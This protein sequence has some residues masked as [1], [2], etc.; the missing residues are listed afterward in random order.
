MQTGGKIIAAVIAGAVFAS[1]ASGSV[2]L[3]VSPTFP[4]PMLVGTDDLHASV[5]ICNAS[6]GFEA[7]GNL[8]VTEIRLTPACGSSESPCPRFP[9]FRRE[10]GV[11]RINGTATG[12]SISFNDQACLGRTFTVELIDAG[13]GEVA[14]EVTDNLGS[15]EVGPSHSA[16][17]CCH[18][19]F[20]V[21]VIAEPKI[22]TDPSLP[23]T[24]TTQTA[25]ARAYSPVTD[26]ETTGYGIG[27]SVVLNTTPTPSPLPTATFTPTVTFTRSSTS[28][29]TRTR[30][31]TATST[32]SRTTTPTPAS[33]PVCPGD[34]DGNRD[35]SIAEVVRCS[36]IYLE[37]LAL[38]QCRVGDTN[39]DGAVSIGEVVRC[40]NS[41]Q[42]GCPEAPTVTPVGSST[43]TAVATVT[44]TGTRTPTRTSSST[45]TA[46]ATLSPPLTATAVVTSA[47]RRELVPC[48]GASDV[49]RFE[50]TAGQTLQVSANTFDVAGAADLCIELKCP[51]IQVFADDPASIQVSAP[52]SGTCTVAVA[53]CSP[54]CTDPE[55]ARYELQV[56]RNA[57]ITPLTLIGDGVPA[58]IS[59]PPKVTPTATPTIAADGGFSL[60]LFR[61]D[62]GQTYVLLGMERV[63]LNPGEQVGAFGAQ[64]TSMAISTAAI[65]ARNEP[66]PLSGDTVVSAFAVADHS[67]NI[68]LSAVFG[69]G[70]V[71]GLSS[72]EI[73]DDDGLRFNGEFLPSAN[74]GDGLLVLPGGVRSVAFRGSATEPVHNLRTSGGS[75]MPAAAVTQITRY[76]GEGQAIVFPNPAAVC[77]GGTAAGAG[78]SSDADCPGPN[79]REHR[80]SKPSRGSNCGAPSFIPCGPPLVTTACGPG[81]VCG[82]GGEEAG[83]NVT[84]DD[85]LN[86]R[87]GNPGTQGEQV[88]GFLLRP[89]RA[90]VAFIV[91][92]QPQFLG[93][94]AAGFLVTGT[95]M[96]GLNDTASCTSDAQCGGGTCS[97]QLSG[98][99]NR[100]TVSTSAV[101]EP[102]LR[103][104]PI[105]NRTVIA[106][107]ELRFEVT[108]S[109]PVERRLSFEA[110]SLPAGA[111][112][113][114][115][116]DGTRNG[117]VT[118]LDVPLIDLTG[119]ETIDGEDF[120][121]LVLDYQFD[122]PIN[123]FVFLWTPAPSQVGQHRVRFRAATP[124]DATGRV[125]FSLPLD[126]LIT[127]MPSSTAQEAVR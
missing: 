34:C 95:C 51:G 90:V 101:F 71:S 64:V 103:L 119:D 112:L 31:L 2:G 87:V 8:V 17:A 80:C 57:A 63:R 109:G 115:A 81:V 13:T 110:D 117:V 1:A 24:S 121:K 77:V 107:K 108:T 55:I 14:F 60:Q 7:H 49:W 88:D 91:D 70:V 97:T 9:S 116:G 20:Q 123:R 56:R 6:T 16:T 122:V 105:S 125:S 52:S 19:S 100:G 92:T 47:I 21:D 43:P 35:V 98:R 15:V 96:G 74:G 36:L 86:E 65:V 11:F 26:L 25:Q 89:L 42:F 12:E 4:N 50:A 38:S 69:T 30:T 61:S 83:Q 118:S 127:V 94:G 126:V 33:N 124:A 104:A 44:R 72:V 40:A 62:N 22:N 41:Y 32:P 58:V 79:D 53:V 113:V 66:I 18:I 93:A 67:T 82:L 10:P 78:C 39:A 59:P 99:L 84:I 76:N 85:T 23:V 54:A 106:G 3:G 68:P 111:Q 27:S 48:F 45:P 29:P 114:S 46:T 5:T 37:T 75:D 73:I 102:S 120:K 28:T